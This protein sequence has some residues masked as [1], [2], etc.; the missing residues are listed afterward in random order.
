RRGTSGEP[1]NCDREW[2]WLTRKGARFLPRSGAVRSFCGLRKIQTSNWLHT[3]RRRN[4]WRCDRAIQKG[5]RRIILRPHRKTPEPHRDRVAG[6][7]SPQ[8]AAWIET[9][10][11]NF[12]GPLLYLA[13]VDEH[14]RHRMHRASE[15]EIGGIIASAPVAGARF[16][17]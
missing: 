1:D 6:Q 16:R 2:R 15:H 8:W 12:A 13:D 4:T 10:A 14:S 11:D 17:A 7:R 5:G 3:R 9:L